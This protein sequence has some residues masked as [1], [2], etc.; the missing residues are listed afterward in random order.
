MVPVLLIVNAELL[1]FLHRESEIEHFFLL[2]CNRLDP[3]ML[4]FEALPENNTHLFIFV[5]Q[6]CEAASTAIATGSAAREWVD[7]IFANVCELPDVPKQIRHASI[8][9]F[10]VQFFTIL[11]REVAHH[12]MVRFVEYRHRVDN[13]QRLLT[14]SVRLLPLKAACL[15]QIR[16]HY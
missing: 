13:F 14:P 2:L 11:L 3:K 10:R 4:S 12:W 15:G 9:S 7:R 1:N 5:E 6:R 16:I 8:D